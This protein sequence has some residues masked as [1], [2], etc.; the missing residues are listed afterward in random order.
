M[1][2]DRSQPR[3]FDQASRL[4]A[5][6]V[7]LLLITIG[8]SLIYKRQDALPV[9][10][11]SNLVPAERMLRGEVVYR[12]FF[13]IQTPGILFYNLWL[14]KLFGTSLLTALRGVLVFKVLTVVAAFLL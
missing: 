4:I 2:L 5:A 6:I 7:V 8:Y 13:M 14:F 12:D 3:V 11:G 10:I 9:G 1:E